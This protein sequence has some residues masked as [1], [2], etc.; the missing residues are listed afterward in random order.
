MFQTIHAIEFLYPVHAYKNDLF[1]CIYQKTPTHI[2]LW[3]WNKN[4]KEADQIL[5]SRF[6][7]AGF[8][9]LPDGDGFSFIDQ[10]I[11]KVKKFF[12]RSPR[13]IEFDAPI[14]QVE[15]VHWLDNMLCYTSGKYNNNFGIFQ[16]DYEGEVMPLY[17]N[18]ASD[19]LYPQK[20]NDALFYIERTDD[21]YRIMQTT[22][23][24]CTGMTFYDRLFA[25][26]Q[27]DLQ[28][29]E[30]VSFSSQPIIFLRMISEQEGFVIAH[31]PAI[32]RGSKKIAFDYYVLKKEKDSWVRTQLFSFNVPSDFLFI[33]SPARLYESILPLL[34]RHY[35][36][37][38][39]FLDGN[40]LNNTSLY[41]YDM[42][43]GSFTKLP[44]TGF[45]FPPIDYVSGG[46]LD[47]Q[48]GIKIESGAVLV[49]M[50][51]LVF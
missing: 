51:S 19:C 43:V 1:Y 12:K 15:V 10:G 23:E 35:G 7:P 29:T 34:P 27:M 3:Q 9:L 26:N 6:T 17:Y 8:C 25:H 47:K 38:I 30:I 36:H 28:S 44:D 46:M 20:C 18:E 33:G 16:I 37:T 42:R 49:N 22:Y 32:S 24:P 4:T 11:L 2:E 48:I 13:T 45:L 41:A 14:Y 39:V 21:Q 40:D 50:G 5:F 31:P